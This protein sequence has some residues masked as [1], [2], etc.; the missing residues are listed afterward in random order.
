MRAGKERERSRAPSGRGEKKN[1]EKEDAWCPT[2]WQVAHTPQPCREL[3]KGN[4]QDRKELRL[5]KGPRERRQRNRRDDRG[6]GRQME[7]RG[8]GRGEMRKDEGW[9]ERVGVGCQ[10]VSGYHLMSRRSN[11]ERT[12]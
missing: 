10:G 1:R 7:K 9:Y 5:F 8:G 12:N 3:T 2:W 6:T 11:G 4:G